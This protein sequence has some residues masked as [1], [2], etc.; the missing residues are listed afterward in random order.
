LPDDYW[1]LVQ[2]GKVIK[3]GKGKPR[4]TSSRGQELMTVKYAK[5][6]MKEDED[7]NPVGKSYNEIDEAAI[8]VTFDVEDGKKFKNT[9]RD[10]G[11][12]GKDVKGDGG[13]R[14]DSVEVKGDSKKLKKLVKDADRELSGYGILRVHDNGQLR[15]AAI[16]DLQKIV[17]DKQHGKVSGVKVDLFTASAMLKVYDALKSSNKKKVEKMLKDKRGVMTFADFAMSQV[18]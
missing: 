13:V 7:K 9:L 15:E 14:G 1:V 18:K 6:M 3:S 17:K 16:D 11:L 8:I 5:K 10:F 4:F 12:R 2:G